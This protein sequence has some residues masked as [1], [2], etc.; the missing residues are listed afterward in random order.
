MPSTTIYSFGDVVLV[1]FPFTNLLTTK[2]RPAIV[3]SHTTYQ[4]ARPD[5]ILMAITS[6]TRSAPMIGEFP[7]Q[8]W[9]G[10]GLAKPSLVKPLI[11][12]LEQSQIIRVLGKLA[13]SDEASLRKLLTQILR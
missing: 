3:I 5:I 1:A 8:D 9:Q 12:T 7:L 13:P 4:A 6:Q 11:A 10:A 2:K